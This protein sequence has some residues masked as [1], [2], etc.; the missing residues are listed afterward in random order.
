MMQ[1]PN[2]IYLFPVPIGVNIGIGTGIGFVYGKLANASPKLCALCFAIYE[3]AK[4]ILIGMCLFIN[5]Q[6][7]ITN[8]I[9]I[10]NN[11]ELTSLIVTQAFLSVLS[12]QNLISKKSE[13]VWRLIDF[14]NFNIKFRHNH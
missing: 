12:Q 8:E 13:C 10:H 5:Q 14:I 11:L 2:E 4:V 3:V 6:L 7:K 1:I 9:T